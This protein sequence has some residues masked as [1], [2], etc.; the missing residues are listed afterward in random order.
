MLA[1][2]GHCHPSCGSWRQNH[3]QFEASLS[4]IQPDPVS[5]SKSKQNIAIY[6]FM[7]E[8]SGNSFQLDS[9]E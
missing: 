3:L 7:E 5:M 6:I 8:T 1:G 4:Y 2:H 9:F